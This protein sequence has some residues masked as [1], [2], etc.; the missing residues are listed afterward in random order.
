MSADILL[1]DDGNGY[2]YMS[3]LSEAGKAFVA[4]H[5]THLDHLGRVSI[6]LAGH[7]Q[8][9]ADAKAAGLEVRVQ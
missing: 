3:A 7:T 6:G 8:V 9:I 5:S 2:H 4:A 1:Q